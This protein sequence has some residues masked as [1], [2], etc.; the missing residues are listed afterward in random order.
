MMKDA[1]KLVQCHL[2]KKKGTK[3]TAETRFVPLHE[4]ELWK[5]YISR[6]HGFA[7][8]KEEIFLW[9]PEKEFEKKKDRL[10]HV[11]NIPV[12]KLTLYFFLKNE[13]VLVPVTRFFRES[14]Y[15]KVK[16]LFLRHFEEFQDESHMTKVLE[17]VKEE[18]GVCMKNP[19]L[20]Q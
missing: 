19:V 7:I 16:P 1:I 5:Y 10:S 13:G 14:D 6:Q 11:D 12:H 20:G 18:R 2:T 8:S 17:H 3:T 4:Y 9:L 15:S